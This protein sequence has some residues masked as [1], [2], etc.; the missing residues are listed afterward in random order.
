MTSEYLNIVL[1]NDE[2]NS[3]KKLLEAL[4]SVDDI[5]RTNYQMEL[6][7]LAMRV[8]AFCEPEKPWKN[9]P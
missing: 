7:G 6:M 8:K 9:G 2:S 5:L 4:E 3:L 1:T